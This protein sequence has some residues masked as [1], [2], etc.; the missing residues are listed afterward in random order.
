MYRSAFRVPARHRA[1]AF[2][3]IELLVVIVIIAILAALVLPA[4]SRAKSKAINIACLNNE[5]QLIVCWQSYATENADF[6]VPN[7]SVVVLDT[8]GAAFQGSS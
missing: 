5:R 2:S 7:N 4:L 8:G 6:V 3:L 1:K